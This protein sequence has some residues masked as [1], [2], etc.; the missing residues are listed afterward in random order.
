MAR[1]RKFKKLPDNVQ[2]EILLSGVSM[3][4]KETNKKKWRTDVY[5]VARQYLNSYG[6]RKED[7]DQIKNMTIDELVQ[8]IMENEV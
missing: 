2:K 3:A 6:V 8:N 5:G 7:F 1:N 4:L